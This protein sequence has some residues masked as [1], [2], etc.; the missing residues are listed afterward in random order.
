MYSSA[1]LLARTIYGEAANQPYE[2]QL[3]VAHSILNRLKS[4]KYGGDTM[5]DV[6]WKPYQYEPW[7]TRRDE[8]LSLDPESDEYKKYAEIAVKA[9]QDNSEGND[10]TGGATHFLNPEIVRRR[11]GGSLPSWFDQERAMQVGDHWFTA[12]DDPNW[13]PAMGMRH[14]HDL[15]VDPADQ[16][17]TEIG[18]EPMTETADAFDVEG[19]MNS[20]AM[21]MGMGLLEDAQQKPVS[22]A[23]MA[24]SPLYRPKARK[25][26]S[27]RGLLG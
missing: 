3:A 9:M 7:M 5:Q 23:Q 24:P 11:R 1:D 2:G 17:A 25:R 20:K 14:E 16:A 15:A 12:A 10:P 6:L 27:L 21:K 26:G 22:S 13:R 8:L 4:G 18:A 19:L